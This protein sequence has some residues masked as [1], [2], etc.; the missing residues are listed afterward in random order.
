[1]KSELARGA[2][3]LG[4]NSTSPPP[5]PKKRC[6]LILVPYSFDDDLQELLWAVPPQAGG[7]GREHE[8]QQVRH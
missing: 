2:V 7:Q 6:L 8:G 1:M 3:V 5:T 4:D